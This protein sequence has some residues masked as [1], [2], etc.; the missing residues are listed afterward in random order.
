MK[1]RN[2]VIVYT[3]GG[4]D[5][6]PGVGGW[7][8]VLLFGDH[9][10]ELSGGEDES[11]N[12]RMDLIAAIEAL[13][14]LQRPCRVELHTDSEYLKKGFT[15]WLPDWKKRGWRRKRGAVKNE[16]LWRRLDE[17]VGRHDVV[18][19]WVRGHTGVDENERCDTLAA[20]EIARRKIIL[21]AR[22]G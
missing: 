4:C 9:R 22:S 16:D 21:G 6:N 1:D 19:K 2:T 8:A 10:K 14:T 13:E 5:P 17:A 15:T 18:W 20:Q 7:G 3:D 11:T 12:N